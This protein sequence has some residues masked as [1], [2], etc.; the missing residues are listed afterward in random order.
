MLHFYI[1]QLVRFL[2]SSNLYLFIFPV[3]FWYYLT[4]AMI[5][6]EEKWLKEKF[7]SDYLD[8]AKKVSRFV[9]LLRI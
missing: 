6:T 1:S 7:G 4:V 9:P 5:R 8:Y 2:L 3:I